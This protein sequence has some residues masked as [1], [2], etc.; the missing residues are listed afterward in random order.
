MYENCDALALRR[1]LFSET[2]YVL[3]LFT[4][5]F[6]RVDALAKGARRRRNPLFGHF[7]FLAYE[8]ITLFRRPRSGLDLATAAAFYSDF[9]RLRSVPARFA[10]AGIFAEIL[11]AACQPSDPHRVLFDDLLATL[12]HLDAGGNI[13]TTA[14]AG[15][16]L[17]LR[18]LGFAPRLHECVNCGA[19]NV[20]RAF[21]SPSR[22]GLVC[23]NCAAASPE[24]LLSRLDLARLR[25]EADG[26]ARTLRTLKHYAEYV[27]GRELVSFHLF[28]RLMP[29]G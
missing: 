3:T 25:G 20:A 15:L 2:S 27:L 1:Y 6:G 23:E 22:G 29:R 16:L 26:D 4:R 10:A 11:L 21:L 14:T 13:F 28:F 18:E 9:P 5:E 12:R 19:T 17:M 7:D 24:F 8:E